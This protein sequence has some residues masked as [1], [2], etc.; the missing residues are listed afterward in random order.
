MF[1][2][3]NF[4]SF[5]IRRVVLLFWWFGRGFGPGSRIPSGLRCRFLLARPSRWFAR[6]HFSVLF[7]LST[8]SY[9]FGLSISLVLNGGEKEA[10]PMPASPLT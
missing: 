9:F 1:F 8:R 2:F 10:M 4:L 3:F 5:R 7:L 6:P